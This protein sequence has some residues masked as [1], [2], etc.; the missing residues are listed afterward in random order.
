MPR[1]VVEYSK[2]GPGGNLTVEIPGSA[3]DV[4]ARLFIQC[5]LCHL[6]WFVRHNVAY[7]SNIQRIMSS[8]SP[9]E[10][11]GGRVDWDAHRDMITELYLAKNLTLNEVMQIMGREHNFRATTRMYKSRLKRWNVSKKLNLEE[12]ERI[13][14][15]RASGDGL[16]VEHM[17]GKTSNDRVKRYLRRMPRN[18]VSQLE[19]TIHEQ[20]V[21]SRPRKGSARVVA[22]Q[23]F[24]LPVPPRMPED[25]RIPEYCHH[26][27]H[28]YLSGC[29]DQGIWAK[30]QVAAGRTGLDTVACQNRMTL[31]AILMQNGFTELGFR[32]LEVG[33]SQYKLCFN[34]SRELA[35]TRDPWLITMVY[36]IYVNLAQSQPALADS[37]IRFALGLSKIMQP[38]NHP[39]R[40]LL[41]EFYRSNPR[42]AIPLAENLV[43]NYLRM[44][45]SDQR[46][47][48]YLKGLPLQFA[49]L[50]CCRQIAEWGG[51]DGSKA[52]ASIQSSLEATT[53]VPHRY[54]RQM[55]A[56]FVKAQALNIHYANGDYERARETRDEILS[57]P[58]ELVSAHRTI[59]AICHR[60]SFL[61]ETKESD[62]DARTSA[63]ASGMLAVCQDNFGTGNSWTVRALIETYAHARRSGKEDMAKQLD[64]QI[65][66][67]VDELCQKIDT[68]ELLL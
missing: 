41:S 19:R 29:I 40:L 64:Q 56:L 49:L 61:L 38:E 44:V 54:Q 26:S 28:R 3:E 6:V 60:I 37:F 18:K 68:L 2:R 53:D 42:Y 23:S 51:L 22:Y 65:H 67:A 10:D 45:K 13:L 47:Q 5:H 9:D 59:P 35:F 16:P 17:S 32:V 27:I 11:S 43:W 50:V 7:A 46:S 62:G 15:E 33:F 25:L 58:K 31:T 55:A 20:A 21:F 66:A 57:A 34:H 8:T 52:D 24:H 12:V 39:F 1:P 4:L 48:G 63:L 36:G 14:I 30:Y